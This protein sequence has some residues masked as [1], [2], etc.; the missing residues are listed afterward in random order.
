MTL[1]S[2][3]EEEWKKALGQ[4]SNDIDGKLDRLEFTP[5]REEL[6]RQLKMLSRKLKALDMGQYCED[7]AAGIRKQL[8]QRFH[9]ISCDRQ[10]GHGVSTNQTASLIRLSISKFSPY[11]LMSP[12]H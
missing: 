4:L 10:V 2:P 8:I 3:Q 6:E 5:I 11:L 12:T 1:N 7:D 9:C